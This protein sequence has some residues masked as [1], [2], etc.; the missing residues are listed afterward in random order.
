MGSVD[1]D[2]LYRDR[3]TWSPLLLVIGVVLQVVLLMLAFFL[4]LA[5]PAL[6][7]AALESAQSPWGTVAWMNALAAFVASL[8]ALLIVRRRFRSIVM[9][10]VHCVIPTVVV[11][12]ANI[13]PTYTVRS[14]LSIMVVIVFAAIASLLS[15]L[16]YVFL[17]KR[18]DY[19]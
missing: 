13:I 2:V 9:V 19:F 1:H 16:M 4:M 3:V 10:V 11:S 14:W 12:A 18:G 17:L 6:T 5:V 7:D 8:L 15:S